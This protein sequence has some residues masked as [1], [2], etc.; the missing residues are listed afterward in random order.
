MSSVGKFGIFTQNQ[1]LLFPRRHSQNSARQFAQFYSLHVDLG[2]TWREN[3]TFVILPD[4]KETT[5]HYLLTLLKSWCSFWSPNMINSIETA[6]ISTI[7]KVFPDS[8]IIGCNFHFSQRLWRQ[9]HNIRL[10]SGM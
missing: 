4:K 6:V 1:N 2:S 3:C 7:S 8:V 9:T 5:R 10:D